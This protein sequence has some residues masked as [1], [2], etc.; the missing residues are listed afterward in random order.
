MEGAYEPSTESLNLRAKLALQTPSLRQ[1]RPRV[2]FGKLPAHTVPTLA[3]FRALLRHAPTNS[4]RLRVGMLFRK[5]RGIIKPSIAKEELLRGYRWLD[6]FKRANEGDEHLR[7]VMERYSR[8]IEL[9]R[10]QAYYD[11]VLEKELK[12]QAKLASRPILTGGYMRPTLFLPPLP[13][14]KPQPKAISAMYRHRV[15][16][17]EANF[18]ILHAMHDLISH[19]TEEA[20]FEYSLQKMHPEANIPAI[21]NGE[22][23][24]EW[25][26]PF[27]WKITQLMKYRE[28]EDQRVN[29]PLSPEL[30]AQIKQARRNKIEN[31]TRERER[32]QRGEILKNTLKRMRKGPPAHVLALMSPEKKRMDR[33]ARSV[34]EV[35]YVAQVKKKLGHKLRDPEAWKKEESLEKKEELD[36]LAEFIREENRRDLEAEGSAENGA[37]EK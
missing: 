13:R 15:R 36:K 27:R 18:V 9:K 30:L 25:I 11:K 3:L 17:H 37:I 1:I 19:I 7:K 33:I 8:M 16:K 22:P 4:I 26:E 12:W 24:Q 5:N 32:E 2:T 34:S 35:G 28:R 20:K 6:M 10:T 29:T 31:K 23:Y 14:M 21:F